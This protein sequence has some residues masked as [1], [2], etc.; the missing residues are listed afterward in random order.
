[1][2]TIFSFWRYEHDSGR[3]QLVEL[4]L[5]VVIR[6]SIGRNGG[7]VRVAGRGFSWSL[8]SEPLLFS[9]RMKLTGYIRVGRWRFKRLPVWRWKPIKEKR[10][11]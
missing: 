7:W 10:G 5:L 1:M 3:T 8:A 9:E 11:S 4:L 6:I 2:S